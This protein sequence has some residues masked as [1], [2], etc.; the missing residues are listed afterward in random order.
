MCLCL[1]LPQT[2]RQQECS[3]FSNDTWRHAAIGCRSVAAF[4]V[5]V[6]LNIVYRLSANPP[7][8][9]M[10]SQRN[11]MSANW[12]ISQL[13]VNEL[14]VRKTSGK[15]MK[16]PPS[17]FLRLL[18]LCH[19]SVDY[20]GPL[21]IALQNTMSTRWCHWQSFWI[22]LGISVNSVG[23]VECLSTPTQVKSIPVLIIR[24]PDGSW[25][26]RS[27]TARSWTVSSW[28]A[29]SWQCRILTTNNG[30][31]LFDFRQ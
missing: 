20:T 6:R 31:F 28:T 10:T 18:C 25:T 30:Y 29:S 4:V 12:L 15:Q 5:F 14:V 13:T 8:R 11:V 2:G 27:W 26:V 16:H 21:E 17:F 19:S 9:E 1:G 24:L 23:Y 3:I 7:I 22:T